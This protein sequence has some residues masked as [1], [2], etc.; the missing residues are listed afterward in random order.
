V[1]GK[2]GMC[3]MPDIGVN[4][5]VVA[6]DFCAAYTYMGFPRVPPPVEQNKEEKGEFEYIMNN[7]TGV[8]ST[9]VV[10][11]HAVMIPNTHRVLFWTRGQ[12]PNV[13]A[14]P[15]TDF[16]VSVVYDWSNG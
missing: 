1:E 3:I 6:A 11:V 9:G 8:S 7:D 16:A 5:T 15:G 4:Y 13:P 2:A 12:Q 10:P 14:Q